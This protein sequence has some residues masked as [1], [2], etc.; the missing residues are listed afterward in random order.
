MTFD[1][2]FND[3]PLKTLTFQSY[4]DIAYTPK[5]FTFQECALESEQAVLETSGSIALPDK[6]GKVKL[7]MKGSVE[8]VMALLIGSTLMK[9]QNKGVQKVSRF[10]QAQSLD[11]TFRLDHG[12]IYW[13]FLP[14]GAL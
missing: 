10:L 6:T 7:K 9:P 4:G 14:I 5:L 3:A 1:P 2:N 11:L 12:K 8:L 13:G